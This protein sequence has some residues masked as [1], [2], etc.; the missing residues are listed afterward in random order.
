[1]NRDELQ[2]RWILS[3]GWVSAELLKET[4]AALPRAPGHDLCSLL[5]MRGLINEAAAAQTRKALESGRNRPDSSRYSDEFKTMAMPSPATNPKGSSRR[6][7]RDSRQYSGIQQPAYTSESQRYSR[8][9]FA[10][11]TDID[12]MDTIITKEPALKAQPKLQPGQRFQDY[13]I[14]EEISRGSM[15]VVYKARNPEGE[16]LALKIIQAQHENEENTRRFS[17]EAETLIRLEHPNIIKV[18]DYGSH[19]GRLF[20]AMDRVDGRDLLELVQSSIRQSGRPP[21]W[22]KS[23]AYL[24]GIARALA[25]C[26]ENHIIHRDVKPQNVM[27]GRKNLRPIL[28]DFGL[29]KRVPT[30][31]DSASSMGLTK[32]GETVG[33]P[34]FMSPEQLD[35]QGA[36]GAIGPASDVWGFGATLFY[37]LTGAAPYPENN[38]M[39]I[40]IALLTRDPRRALAVNPQ[41]P[42]WLDELCHRCLQRQAEDRIAL[43][44]VVE[45]LRAAR[46]L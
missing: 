16:V 46:A 3:Q 7:A 27:I 8:D 17:R 13:E 32:T 6:F 30:L 2:A 41:V 25:H 22:R 9:G 12:N 33:T 21:P 14:L 44:E 37:C 31:A 40:Y 10:V 11:S 5:L 35:A 28:V 15:G 38:A 4:A 23:V 29:M 26:H 39:G 24:E 1:M 20:Y 45:R 43:S 18:R 36:H 42:E 19:H 34:A